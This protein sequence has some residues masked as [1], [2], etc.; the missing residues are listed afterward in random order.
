MSEVKLKNLLKE[1]EGFY[2]LELYDKA[3]ERLSEYEEDGGDWLVSLEMRGEVL[4]AAE[5]YEEAVPVLE[6]VSH[7]K[8]DDLHVYIGLGWCY[9]RTDRLDKAVDVLESAVRADPNFSLAKYNLAC[10]YALAGDDKRCFRFLSEA[11]SRDKNFIRM[12]SE[13]SDFDNVRDAE[14]FKRITAGK[15]K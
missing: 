12:A 14:E 11:V 5:R 3:L 9:K 10:Y 7:V 13:E 4:R 1:A 6:R 2:E 8:P 15:V